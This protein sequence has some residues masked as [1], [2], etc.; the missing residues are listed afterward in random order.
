MLIKSQTKEGL[1]RKGLHRARAA[2][3]SRASLLCQTQAKD[4]GRTHILAPGNPGTDTTRE[5]GGVPKTPETASVF[6]TSGQRG[7]VRQEDFHKTPIR[8]VTNQN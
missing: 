3:Q 2:A 6:F 4:M 1:L 5:I 8:E 7:K